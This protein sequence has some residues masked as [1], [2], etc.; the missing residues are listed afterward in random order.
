MGGLVKYLFGPGRHEEHTNQRIVGGS[1]PTWLGT[2][3]PNDQDL[4]QLIAELDDPRVRHGDRTKNGHVYHLVVSLPEA[5]GQV[6]DGQWQETAQ[7]FADRLGF[8]EH[9]HWVAIHHGL[10]SK[11]NDHIHM[12]AN[13][14]RGDGRTANLWQDR[15]RRREVCIE[16][17]EKYGLTATAPAGLGAEALTRGEVDRLRQGAVADIVDLGKYR[18]ATVVRA[19]AAGARSEPEFIERL[20]GEGLVVRPYQKDDQPGVVTGYS[21]A[22]RSNPGERAPL[23][24]YGGGRLGKDLR[25]PALRTKWGQT[26]EQRKAAAGAWFSDATRRRAAE[27]R[28]LA[29]AADALR[30]AAG[31]LQKVPPEDRFSWYIAS[32][33]AAGVVAAAAATTTDDRVRRDLIRAWKAINQATPTGTSAGVDV[34]AG[35]A[36][37]LRVP[38]VAGETTARPAVAWPT[39]QTHP[40]TSNTGEVSALLAGASRVLMAARLADAPQHAR[41]QALL[42]QAIELAAQISRT[43]AAQQGATASQRRAAEATTQAATTTR[44]AAR[45]GWQFT[46]T[47]AEVLEASRTRRAAGDELGADPT[48]Q[49]HIV[50]GPQQPEP[51]R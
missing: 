10:S 51:E 28:N 47:G 50:R 30:Q 26:D 14:I 8:D 7:A 12:V 24:W 48:A 43:I 41:V 16:L 11:G 18:L 46:Q 40:A 44:G 32:T 15:I 37:Q 36:A 9:V 31:R 6:R 20:R 3:T 1:D 33:E 25:L 38:D 27:P 19:V 13:L 45:G 34:A 39:E 35:D 49:P 17:E 22:Q 5:D 2:T 4:A 29:G 42:V 23:V 21:V